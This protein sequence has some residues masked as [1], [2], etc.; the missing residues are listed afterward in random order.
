M[1]I[2]I[3]SKLYVVK[4]TLN[5][6]MIMY[7]FHFILTCLPGNLSECETVLLQFLIS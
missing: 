1:F 4:L 5:S 2:I 6:C 7:L 3:S